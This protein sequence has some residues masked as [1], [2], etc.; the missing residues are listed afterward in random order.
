MAAKVLALVSSAVIVTAEKYGGRG[1]AESVSDLAFSFPFWIAVLTATVSMI[2]IVGGASRK[3][4][5]HSA[6]ASRWA[7][8]LQDLAECEDDQAL[9]PSAA[10]KKAAAIVRDELPEMGALVRLCHRE[11]QRAAGFGDEELPQVPRLHEV[12]AD[13]WDFPSKS[14][15]KPG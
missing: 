5:Q 12:L 14:K 6:L 7:E 4:V 11:V 13:Y 8:V 10:R 3:A 15:S 1:P 9:A 2:V